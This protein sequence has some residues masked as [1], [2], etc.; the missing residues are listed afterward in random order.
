M[1]VLC[2]I[3]LGAFADAKTEVLMDKV[4]RMEAELAL[5]QRKLYQTPENS[6]Q[7]APNLPTN[8][9]DFYSQLDAQ[10]QVIQD[11][12]QKVERLEFELSSLGSKVDR[13]NQDV[14]F[15]LNELN[16]QKKSENYMQMC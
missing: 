16:T 13:V 15:R 5:V 11:L 7:K 3:S 8:I 4:E 2:S 10:N 14:D 9:D 1:F 12:T 6:V